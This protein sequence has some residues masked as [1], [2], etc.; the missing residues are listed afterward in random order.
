MALMVALDQMA[1]VGAAPGRLF[2]PYRIALR[3]ARP[4]PRTH[5]CSTHGTGVLHR[6]QGPIRTHDRYSLVHHICN[7]TV[8]CPRR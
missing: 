3:R 7:Y 6:P 5:C 8:R 2:M 4:M 1:P